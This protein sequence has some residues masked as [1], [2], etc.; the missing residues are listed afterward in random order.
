MLDSGLLGLGS[1]PSQGHCIV[2]LGK[3]LRPGVYIV[4]SEY[5]AGSNPAM[6][7]DLIRGGVEILLVTKYLQRPT[8]SAF[9]ATS[10]ERRLYTSTL[11][12]NSGCTCI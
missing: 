1:S 12:V 9:L 6:D 10:P 4:T 3:T 7:K 11:Q 2:F 5:N 8:A